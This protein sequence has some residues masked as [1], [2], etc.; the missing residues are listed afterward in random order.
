ME[1]LYISFQILV[2]FLW[3]AFKGIRIKDDVLF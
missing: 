1:W 3:T 2:I